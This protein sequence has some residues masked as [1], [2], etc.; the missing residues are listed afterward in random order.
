MTGP[1]VDQGGE[2]DAESGSGS[3][4]QASDVLARARVAAERG[5]DFEPPPAGVTAALPGLAATVE[6]LAAGMTD[7]D[8]RWLAAGLAALAD[9]LE[10]TTLPDPPA[11]PGDGLLFFF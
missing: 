11:R 5:L 9:Q 7:Q 8:R 4:W 3:G 6:H 1:G 2:S 10:R